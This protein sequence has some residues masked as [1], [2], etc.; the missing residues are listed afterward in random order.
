MIQGAKKDKK[1]LAILN[2]CA[3][4]CS[5]AGKLSVQD[6]DI[7][8][9]EERKIFFSAVVQIC[10]MTKFSQSWEIP[11]CADKYSIKQKISNDVSYRTDTHD[12]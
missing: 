10:L 5:R 3:S 2:Y 4:T 7:A 1:S 9:M 12:K 8:S 6:V 11:F